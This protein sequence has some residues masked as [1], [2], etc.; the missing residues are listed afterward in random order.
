MAKEYGGYLPF[1]IK[2]GPDFFSEY[3]EN[4]V[5]RTNSA[6]AAM[7][8]VIK[9]KGIQKICVPYY[10]CR[11][12]KEML[13]ETG[14][15]I[16]YYDL[17][18]NLLPVPGSV[19][20]DAAVLLVDYFGMMEEQVKREA[21]KYRT[22]ILDFSHSFFA[23]PVVREGAFSIYSCRKFVG[24]PDG[25]YA[26]GDG[27]S[28][29]LEADKVSDYFSY[30]TT[31]LEYGTNAAYAQKQESDRYFMGNYKGMSELTR[32]MLSSVDYAGIRKQRSEN[33]RHLHRILGPYNALMIEEEQAPAYVYP[34]LPKGESA[35]EKSLKAA[36]VA[37]KIYVPTLWK[38]LICE[39]FRGTL[40]YR[41]S[42]QAVFLPVDQRYGKEDMEY[43]AGRVKWLLE[44]CI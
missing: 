44:G 19:D 23:E 7:Y 10:M 8:F 33:F 1:E 2:T 31:S 41:L 35:A 20:A 34:F 43:I 22:V 36:L 30:L 13:Q 32:G 39:E 15:S 29:K 27:V 24:V 3:G 28:R 4:N 42:E 38:E 9:E 37:E 25:G 6:K 21:E 12:V 18:E 17:D 11:S 16:E 40:E 14:V 5:L 26:I